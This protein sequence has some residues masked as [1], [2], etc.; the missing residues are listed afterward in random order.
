MS[1]NRFDFLEL[2]PEEPVDVQEP[3]RPGADITADP[4][5]HEVGRRVDSDGRPLAQVVDPDI[6][7]YHAFLEPSDFP[8]IAS[9]VV[10]G[11]RDYVFEFHVVEVFGGRGIQSGRFNFPGGIAVDPDGVL[12]V[13][14]SYNHRI[15]RITADGGVLIIGGRGS[16][17][18]RFLS[19]QAVAVDQFGSFYVVEQGNHRV[20][21]FDSTGAV[22]LVIEQAG[23]REGELFRP[24]GIGVSP[25]GDIY[26]ADTGN[27]RVQRFD[28]DGNFLAVLGAHSGPGA[29]TTPQA[30]AVDSN[31]CVYISDTFGHTVMRYDPVGRFLGQFGG[32]TY[33]RTGLQSRFIEPRGIGTDPEGLIYVVDTGHMMTDGNQSRGRLQVLD[34]RNGDV[35]LAI[36]RLG[37]N[38]GFLFRPGG[39]A[40]TTPGPV[41]SRSSV[42]GV[43][44]PAGAPQ[45]GHVYVSDTMNHRIVRFAWFVQ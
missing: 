21:K 20:Q 42:P 37:R 25:T 29:M 5:D 26:V 1:E 31:D 38:L 12:F 11:G 3:G 7:G 16:A 34:A 30:V 44:P 9:G 18:G 8:G 17:L 22:V 39:I 28:R 33:G 23:H 36:E 10:A 27:C 15:Q 14:D 13:A 19:P 43:Q 32:R 40:V 41:T 4:D 6:R 45:R 2:T 24:Q 35:L